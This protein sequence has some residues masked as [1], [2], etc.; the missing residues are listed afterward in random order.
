MFGMNL[1]IGYVFVLVMRYVTCGS[2]VEG[3][4]SVGVGGP[5][6][7]DNRADSSVRRQEEAPHLG[8]G[9]K[10]RVVGGDGETEAEQHSSNEE[11]PHHATSATSAIL[12]LSNSIQ[13]FTATSTVSNYKVTVDTVFGVVTISSWAAEVMQLEG[14]CPGCQ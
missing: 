2:E 11:L 7:V 13:T 10:L 4:I 5:Q 3:V 6:S 1:L 12:L 14:A 8:V 9:V